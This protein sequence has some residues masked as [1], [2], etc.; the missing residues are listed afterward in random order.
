MI[1]SPR[2][3]HCPASHPRAEIINKYLEIG[4]KSHEE[5]KYIIPPQKISCFRKDNDFASKFMRYVKLMHNHSEER[6]N[7]NLKRTSKMQTILAKMIDSE[8]LPKESS[9]MKITWFRNSTTKRGGA[10]MTKE[11]SYYNGIIK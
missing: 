6:K 2:G 4:D 1:Q 10:I 3:N 5:N 8:R 7:V 11:I 9:S